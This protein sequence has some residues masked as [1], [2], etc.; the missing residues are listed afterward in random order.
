MPSTDPTSPPT[1]LPSLTPSNIPTVTPSF[2]PTT[3]PSILPSFNPSNS[4]SLYPTLSPSLGPTLSYEPSF[5]TESIY[6]RE[7]SQIFY[8][9]S[10]SSI[11]DEE[12]LHTLEKF[13]MT[14]LPRYISER[15]S[16]LMAKTCSILLQ[17][18]FKV[19]K[20][21]TMERPV[22]F[23][24][25][26]RSRDK[27]GY[28]E[29]R[30]Q[31]RYEISFASKYLDSVNVFQSYIN[32]MRDSDQREE[33]VKELNMNWEF[34]L[35][36]IEEA[37]IISIDP[38]TAVPSDLPSY[39]SS[40]R[41]SMI[42]SQFPSGFERT[43]TPSQNIINAINVS[44]LQQ[45]RSDSN[46]HEL[47]SITVGVGIVVLTLVTASSV[48]IYRVHLKNISQGHDDATSRKFPSTSDSELV[49]VEVNQIGRIPDSNFNVALV[50]SK[51]AESSE[52]S[53]GV[54]IDN[55]L[56]EHPYLMRNLPDLHKDQY[57]EN[58]SEND[59]ESFENSELHIVRDIGKFSCLLNVHLLKYVLLTMNLS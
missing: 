7:I 45:S 15:K 43:P 22:A 32:F 55:N 10:T 52:N 56:F 1:F 53:V 31:I 41:P 49:D 44:K 18:P 3:L 29:T 21:K 40:D 59:F 48:F 39:S 33:L 16:S 36:S 34:E 50:I 47:I 27:R 17:E 58:D 2:T 20:R 11:L 19:R 51:S 12:Q 6:T 46:K 4:P 42:T 5:S 28:F 37:T 13:I 8:L 26:I 54:I 57:L 25:R 9:N 35:T 24:R 14:L 23:L 38:T 30:L